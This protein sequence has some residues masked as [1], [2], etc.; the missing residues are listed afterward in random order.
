MAY[1]HQG[2]RIFWHSVIEAWEREKL[3]ILSHG[4]RNRPTL[5]AMASNKQDIANHHT[6]GNHI[7]DPPDPHVD[8]TGTQ[9]WRPSAHVKSR[10]SNQTLPQTH[11]SRERDQE[12]IMWSEGLYFG[13]FELIITNEGDS[14]DIYRDAM[15]W[16]CV[17]VIYY[18]D[19]SW[20]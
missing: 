4:T 12:L 13:E 5:T 17:N 7:N 6:N 15:Y 16:S 10:K 20:W 1:S 8:N 9:I 3:A 11:I 2:K 14:N 19:N 18:V